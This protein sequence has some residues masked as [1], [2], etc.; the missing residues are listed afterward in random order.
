MSVLAD[1]R[2]I[3]DKV[4]AEVAR[5]RPS[6]LVSA[7]LEELVGNAS[8]AIYTTARRA[9]SLDA[10]QVPALVA[11]FGESLRAAAVVR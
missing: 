11:A 9:G 3:S 4:R 6:L 10:E 5:A 7:H 2:T 8:A 1:Y